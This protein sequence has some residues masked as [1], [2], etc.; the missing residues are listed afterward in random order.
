MQSY[1]AKNDAML[2][3]NSFITQQQAKALGLETR[4]IVE[5]ML[6]ANRT[7]YY[8]RSLGVTAQ[9][10]LLDDRYRESTRNAV[11]EV[12]GSAVPADLIDRILGA[13]DAPDMA[14]PYDAWSVLEEVS[15]EY[16]AAID[17]QAAKLGVTWVSR[18][19]VRNILAGIVSGVFMS[20]IFVFDQDVLPP[21]LQTF[22]GMLL[23]GSGASAPA[24]VKKV[25]EILDKHFPEPMPPDGGR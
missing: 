15:P 9:S 10:V 7:N 20:L 23:A 2:K 16:A 25:D 5:A 3:K 21:A 11:S 19:A 12:V 24:A 4:G 13:S 22:L 1:W 18:E 6:G 17:E 14:T 8:Y